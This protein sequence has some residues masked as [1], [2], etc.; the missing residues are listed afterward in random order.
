MIA[1]ARGTHRTDRRHPPAPPKRRRLVVLRPSPL[2]DGCLEGTT[3]RQDE[4]VRRLS[5]A[6]GDIERLIRGAQAAGYAVRIRP[7]RAAVKALNLMLAGGERLQLDGLSARDRRL[8]E[9]L[10]PAGELA[11]LIRA[12]TSMGVRL[13]IRSDLPVVV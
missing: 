13:E 6:Q 12:A 2:N 10:S 11:S 8:T 9:K 3:P 5:P 1:L 4:L 7:S